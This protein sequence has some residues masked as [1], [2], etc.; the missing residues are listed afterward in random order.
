[1][2]FSLAVHEAG[3]R[4]CCK[5]DERGSPAPPCNEPRTE[6]VSVDTVVAAVERNRNAALSQAILAKIGEERMSRLKG[7]VR[8]APAQVDRSSLN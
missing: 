2:S 5:A 7:K 3:R 8:T 1:M 4:M 6:Q